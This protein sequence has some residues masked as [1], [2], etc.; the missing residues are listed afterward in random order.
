[1]IEAPPP[2][3][4]EPQLVDAAIDRCEHG[5]HELEPDIER[6]FLSQCQALSLNDVADDE[7]RTRLSDTFNLMENTS[8][9][10]VGE[11]LV[12][13]ALNGE[14]TDDWS[15]WDVELPDGTKVEVKTT[16]YVQAWPQR[17][18]SVAAWNVRK[19]QGWVLIDGTYVIDEREERRS[20]LYVF[21]LHD[22]VR[23][24]DFEEWRFYVVPTDRIN[25]EL[26]DQKTVSESSLIHRLGISALTYSGLCR[27]GA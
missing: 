11:V 5:S 15:D 12:A 23:P 24:D 22:G 1:M 26:G 9:G 2:L 19:T 4:R 17:R 20:D 18:A 21:A 10:T 25:V 8:R 27:L 6:S 16:G 3:A 14:V 13:M 7:L